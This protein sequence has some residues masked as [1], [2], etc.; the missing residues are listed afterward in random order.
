MKELRHEYD[1]TR[2]LWCIDRNPADIDYE[3]IKGNAFQLENYLDTST[4]ANDN[5]AV[6]VIGKFTLTR[7]SSSEK[8][9]LAGPSS[10][11][12]EVNEKVLEDL[13]ASLF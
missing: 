10:E 12:T 8:I 6:I 9:W 2:G 7:G 11:G 3:W 5:P 13:L 1:T 4:D